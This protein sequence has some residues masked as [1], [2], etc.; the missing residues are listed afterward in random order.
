[1]R[2]CI[3][4]DETVQGLLA[5][6]GLGNDFAKYCG[7][8]DQ[9]LTGLID[10]MLSTSLPS[11]LNPFRLYLDGLG[12]R[13]TWDKGKWSKARNA[14]MVAISRHRDDVSTVVSTMAVADAEGRLGKIVSLLEQQNINL[15]PGGT[16]ER[17]L[18]LYE[19]EHYQLSESAKQKAVQ[20][21]TGYLMDLSSDEGMAE[22]YGDLTTR[23]AVSR[24]ALTSTSNQLSAPT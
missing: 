3:N 13:S 16:L 15:L 12:D 5:T 18:P 23:S 9:V 19:G 4:N 24:P 17:Y 11:K 8:L 20:A 22:R 10:Q 6:A 2:S 1:M 21:E 7:D 14:L